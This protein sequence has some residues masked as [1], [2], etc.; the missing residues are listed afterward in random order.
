MNKNHKVVWWHSGWH[1]STGGI[2]KLEEAN[3]VFNRLAYRV[4]VC[5]TGHTQSGWQKKKLGWVD[6]VESW[7]ESWLLLPNQ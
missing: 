3:E 5:G 4:S 6:V 1:G 2:N 7:G